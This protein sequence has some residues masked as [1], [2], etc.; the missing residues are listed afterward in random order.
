LV[1]LGKEWPC[2]EVAVKADGETALFDIS[3]ELSVG[4]PME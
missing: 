3:E 1:T 2:V 4:M